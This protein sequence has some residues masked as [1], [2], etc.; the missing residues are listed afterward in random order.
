MEKPEWFRKDFE[1][2]RPLYC[3]KCDG[4]T[5]HKIQL[6]ADSPVDNGVPTLIACVDCYEGW[7]KLKGLGI[8]KP[9]PVFFQR[10]F[11]QP[12]VFLVLQ[13]SKLE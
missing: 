5:A 7:L 9:T 1:I 10:F 13:G 12:Y 11:V 6:I 8:E 3:K 4:V 2:V